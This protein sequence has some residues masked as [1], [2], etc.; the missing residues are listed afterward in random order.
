MSS[1]FKVFGTARVEFASFSCQG[2]KLTA[3][4]SVV[5][6][7]GGFVQGYVSSDGRT[8]QEFDGK[9]ICSLREISR[10]RIPCRNWSKGTEIIAYR[11]TVGGREFS[12]RG[13]GPTMLL[14]LRAR[15]GQ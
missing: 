2:I 15:R 12:G 6:K 7:D 14:R 9:P 10:F 8:L 3:I 5:D 4:G 1:E 11:A 13:S